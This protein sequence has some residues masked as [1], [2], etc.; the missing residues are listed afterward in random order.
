MDIS[1]GYSHSLQAVGDINGDGVPEV[2][3][4][5][6]CN[7]DVKVV[8]YENN[9]GTTDHSSVSSYQN[10]SFS[11]SIMSIL[12]EDIDSDGLIEMSVAL[13]GS[14]G[15]IHIMSPNASS[16]YSLETQQVIDTSNRIMSNIL[17]KD[18]NSDGYLDLV[19]NGDNELCLSISNGTSFDTPLCSS[20][21]E[22]GWSKFGI[23]SYED[24]MFVISKYDNN[25]TLAAYR[26]A[27]YDSSGSYW[28]SVDITI[29]NATDNSSI[30]TSSFWISQVTDLSPDGSGSELF[31]AT[32]SGSMI[33][34]LESVGE[35]GSMSWTSSQS[36]LGGTEVLRARGPTGCR[37]RW[38]RSTLSP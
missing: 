36:F 5:D 13:S 37:Q 10:L 24:D 3:F 14:Q 4:G 2:A 33:I 26:Y 21:A 22:V 23:V 9:G 8:T 35:D 29:S 38:G 6:E 20:N 7:S 32:G 16:N 28:D 17:S 12:M 1:C 25:D 27:G 18:M 31:L 34:Q 30:G 15:E 11:N 19:F